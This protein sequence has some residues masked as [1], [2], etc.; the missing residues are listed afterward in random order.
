MVIASVPIWLGQQL[1]RRNAAALV[2]SS[3]A[4]LLGGLL[5]GSVRA[6][7]ATP[8]ARAV[9][10][11]AARADAPRD[12]QPRGVFE[13]RTLMIA[14]ASAQVWLASTPDGA[15]QICTDDRATITLQAADGAT[16][17][18]TY[19]FA[20]P[21]RRAIMCRPPQALALPA[22][23]GVYTATITLEDLY[24]PTF[25]TRAYYLVA[26]TVRESAAAP[27]RRPVASSPS[28]P[29]PERTRAPQPVAQPIATHMASTAA[30]P[31]VPPAAPVVQRADPSD[32]TLLRDPR[33]PAALGAALVLAIVAL[34][35]R[36][37]LRRDRLPVH[38]LRGVLYLFDPATREA[39]TI[40][41]PGDATSVDIYQRPLR[42]VPIG[43]AD[44][45]DA[46]IAQIQATAGGPVLLE[47]DAP[48][49][50]PIK[51]E[52]DRPYV[53]AGGA[54]TLRYRDQAAGPMRG[55]SHPRRMVGR[56]STLR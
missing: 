7:P 21:D 6:Q 36:R 25:G 47:S 33:V 22:G 5:T 20:G 55:G 26:D 51:I 9:L 43:R 35:I 24:P 17:R 42:A 41:L 53:I 14:L 32:G 16:Q 12:S 48:R 30:P 54:V 2:V 29:T 1:C 19:D 46:A 34:L 11:I 49:T 23:A 10:L 40:A 13:Q 15:G 28:V 45:A 39:R 27:D 56:R 4:L 3:I 52:R 8:P 31:A 37:L 44:G 50:Q 38:Q 18:W